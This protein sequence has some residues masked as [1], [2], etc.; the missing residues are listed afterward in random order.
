MCFFVQSLFSASLAIVLLFLSHSSKSDPP[1]LHLFPLFITAYS[2]YTLLLFLPP[3]LF[4]SLCRLPLI[5]WVL[6]W[7]VTKSSVMMCRSVYSASHGLIY[8]WYEH[9]PQVIL[10]KKKKQFCSCLKMW[11]YECGLSNFQF[12][13][14][15][16][17]CFHLYLLS[18]FV[19]GQNRS[20]HQI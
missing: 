4:H 17:P 8:T 14:H 12:K 13:K 19:I 3:S 18:S 20:D 9:R 5:L 1:F 10:K 15:F 7:M 11:H 6:K 16:G 2:L